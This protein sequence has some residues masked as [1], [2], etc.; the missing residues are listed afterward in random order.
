MFGYRRDEIIGQPVTC[1]IPADRI[2]EHLAAVDRVRGRREKMLYLETQRIRKDGGVIPASL[3]VSAIHGEQDRVIG[4]C[5]VAHDRSG[6]DESA[7]LR[8]V[9]TELERLA[10]Q[11]A[12]ERDRAEQ[13]NRL[14]RI[15]WPA[16]VTNSARL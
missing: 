6:Q 12:V 9:N 13:A 10:G 4:I 5:T 14:D 3:T 1:V 15:S 7:K 2:D 16:S 11:L 8:L